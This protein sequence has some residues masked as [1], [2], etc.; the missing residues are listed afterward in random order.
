[1][2]VANENVAVRSDCDVGRRIELVQASVAQPIQEKHVVSSQMK[3]LGARAAPA[4][5]F[6]NQGMKILCWFILHEHGA[7]LVVSHSTA[8]QIEDVVEV[9]PRFVFQGSADY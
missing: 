5:S 3:S 6:P 9:I 2:S 4:D 8:S 1:V 7:E